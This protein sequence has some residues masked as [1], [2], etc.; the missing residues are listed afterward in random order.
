MTNLAKENKRYFDQYCQSTMQ[1]T[2]T[3]KMTKELYG[4]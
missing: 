1:H 4:F 2:C 3:D